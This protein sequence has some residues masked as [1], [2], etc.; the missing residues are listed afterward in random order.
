MRRPG[1]R[2][3][4]GGAAGIVAG[5]IGGIALTSISVA[6]GPTPAVP[7]LDAVH[8]PPLLTRPDEPVTL[9]YAIVCAPRDDGQP[10]EGSGSVY[11]RAGQTGLFRQLRLRR[12]AESREG[13]YY[14]EVAG[15]DRVLARRLLLLRGASRR[16]DRSGDDR[17]G[18][19][20][21]CAATELPVGGGDRGRTR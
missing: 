8:A 21:G 15:R 7:G 1:I 14:V 13:R 16:N 18:G 19:R 20:G 9:R 6:S 5:V 10:C 12:G 17:S 3:L 2:S 11:V 4:A